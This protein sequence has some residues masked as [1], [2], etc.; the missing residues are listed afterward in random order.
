MTKIISFT[1]DISSIDMPQQIAYPHNYQPHQLA[2]IAANEL[3][4]YLATQT[5]FTHNFGITNPNSKDALGKMFGVLV[6]QKQDKS[7]AYLAAFSGKL[8]DTTQHNHFV[9]PIFDVLNKKGFYTDTENKINQLNTQLDTITTSTDF[10]NIKK[11]YSNLRKKHE[12]LFFDEQSK[13]KIR[14]K[15][16]KLQGKQNNQQ[17][18]N[19]EF[20]LKEY[21]TYLEAKISDLQKEY[22]SYTNQVQQLKEKRKNSSAKVQQQIF[23]QY[24]FL[25]IDKKSKN[26][27]DIF[28]TSSQ[29]IPAGAG[30]CCAPKLLQYAFKHDLK[31]ICMAE[32]W[33]GK[34]LQ[35]SIRKHQQFYAACTGKCKPILSHMLSGLSIEQNPVIAQLQHN[36][37]TISI[38]FE[39]DSLLVINKPYDLLTVAGKEIDDSVFNRI[40]RLYP[41]ATGPLIV[42]RL[43]MSTSGV[44]LIAKNLDVYKKLQQQFITKVVQKRYVALLNGVLSAQ[45]GTIKLPLRVDLDD[46]PKQLVCYEHGKKALTKW[47]KIEVKDGKT[48]VYFYP[49]TGR[50]HQ[51][52]V[53]AAHQLGLNTPI[54]GDDLYGKKSNRLHLHAEKIGF[55]H[56]ITSKWVEFSVPTPF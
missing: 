15:N 52:R 17:N 2:K 50:T 6:V 46:R 7:L 26:L 43:D 37:A 22:T 29:N 28:K 13:I 56:P 44:L 45:N 49:I 34:P 40:R 21:Q 18:I 14:R 38:V 31:P 54:I 10:I 24:Q 23:E 36:E 42:H 25:N 5:D 9:P 30:D 19:E 32:F 41:A 33:W 55:K 4:T 53:H 11:E 39:D 27:F 47:K 12:D 3:Q 1:S 20:Y 8:G 16:R 48:R 51:L 35:T